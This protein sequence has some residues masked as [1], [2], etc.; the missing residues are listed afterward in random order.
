MIVVVVVVVVVAGWM[1][2]YWIHGPQ[3]PFL[4][5]EFPIV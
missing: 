3:G 4:G 5:D 2:R 1:S